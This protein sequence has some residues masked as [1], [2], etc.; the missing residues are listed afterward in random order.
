MKKE[1]IYY[2]LTQNLKLYGKGRDNTWCL[3]IAE[4]K[5]EVKN[6]LDKLPVY[7]KE[8]IQPPYGSTAYCLYLCDGMCYFTGEPITRNVILLNYNGRG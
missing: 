7:T 3:D 4:Y 2:T 5:K 1:E 6:A 8:S